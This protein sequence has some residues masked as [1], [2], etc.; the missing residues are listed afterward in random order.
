MY[1]LPPSQEMMQDHSPTAEPTEILSAKVPD[2]IIKELYKC[3]S[4]PTS[5]VLVYCIVSQADMMVKNSDMGRKGVALTQ[6]RTKTKIPPEVKT[7]LTEL[8]IAG[9]RSSSDRVKQYTNYAC[10]HDSIL[11]LFALQG[12]SSR[13]REEA[14]KPFQRTTTYLVKRIAGMS[15]KCTF[16]IR[17]M[18]IQ[19]FPT[20]FCLR[21]R[22]NLPASRKQS[23][24]H[25]Q[26]M[27]RV[28]AA[29]RVK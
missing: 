28:Q 7:F 20:F 4:L 19:V 13:S 8:F 29:K 27:R 18:R 25:E 12:D 15:I 3:S 21:W 24:S 14:T 17:V 6:P 16:K 11:Y 1:G 26:V 22:V 9:E 10:M 2:S 23:P 5:I